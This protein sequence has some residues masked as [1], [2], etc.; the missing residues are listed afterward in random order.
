MGRKQSSIYVLSW[1]IVVLALGWVGAEP[2]ENEREVLEFLQQA[3]QANL[4]RVKQGRITANA[5]R[6]E[7]DTGGKE[8]REHRAEV[9]AVIKDQ[10]SRLEWMGRWG[11][12][13]EQRLVFTEEVGYSF[14]PGDKYVYAYDPNMLKGHALCDGFLP[15]KSG[16]LSYGR[17]FTNMADGERLLSMKI[18]NETFNDRDVY[19]IDV[20]WKSRPQDLHRHYVDPVSGAAILK[21]EY[22]TDF[23][24][25]QVLA[26]C[27]ESEMQPVE[28]E[29][30]YINRSVRTDY[31]RDGKT[32]RRIH[33]YEISEF[34]FVS[35][36]SDDEFTLEGMGLPSDIKIVDKRFGGLV[37]SMG[38]PAVVEET[39]DDMLNQPLVQEVLT[40]TGTSAQTTDNREIKSLPKTPSKE[41]DTN[42]PSN[43]AS[44]TGG[45]Q[46]TS[47]LRVIH[48]LGG[49]VGL[50][51]LIAL[52]LLIIRRNRI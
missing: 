18:E 24:K 50:G 4:L 17:L 41:F 33:K 26:T 28:G 52:G 14:F 22:Y 43:A 13:K 29:G 27:M 21:W 42:T 5:L 32:L 3:F 45:G 9:T 38:L 46:N 30:W 49:A 36:V 19:V 16:A 20:V 34:D 39:I 31:Q 37:F 48:V 51:M 10:K 25:G 23:G 40:P 11:G 6:S 35:K 1:F 2:V 12:V 47:G 15:S 44:D 8:V 7:Y